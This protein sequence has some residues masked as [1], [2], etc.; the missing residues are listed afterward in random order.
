VTASGWTTAFRT[1]SRVSMK[2]MPSYTAM[3]LSVFSDGE[4]YTMASA[5]PAALICRR[6]DRRWRSAG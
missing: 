1:L 5:Q 6:T 2:W 3:R 4:E